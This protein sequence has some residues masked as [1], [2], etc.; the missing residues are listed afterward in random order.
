MKSIIFLL[1]VLSSSFSF[2]GLAGGINHGN[3]CRLERQFKI[4]AREVAE[5]MQVDPI[6]LF[7]TDYYIELAQKDFANYQKALDGKTTGG[8]PSIWVRVGFNCYSLD[9]GNRIRVTMPHHF[10]REIAQSFPSDS[11]DNYHV[12]T[13]FVEQRSDEQIVYRHDTLTVAFDFSKVSKIEAAETGYYSNDVEIIL[14]NTKGDSPL[15]GLRV[16]TRRI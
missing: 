7:G 14:L 1:T 4:T 10:K 3:D 16:K 8:G 12:Y 2:A 13:N 15:N 5:H 9:G 11:E 6:E